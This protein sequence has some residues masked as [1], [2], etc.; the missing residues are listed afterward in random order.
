MRDIDKEKKD[1]RKA[2][3]LALREV[4]KQQVLQT[5]LRASNLAEA[6]KTLDTNASELRARLEKY[7][8]KHSQGERWN[9]AVKDYIDAGQPYQYELPVPTLEEFV[10]KPRFLNFEE[11]NLQME[12]KTLQME[13][14]LEQESRARNLETKLKEK[15]EEAVREGY[16][17]AEL[18][19][20]DPASPNR[21]ITYTLPLR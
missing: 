10:D 20:S 1:Q 17:E 7:G 18:V 6:A 2:E 11:K 16:D 5:V 4:R 9:V 12:F 13:F 15:L 19:V 21:M 3:S 14:K 8:V